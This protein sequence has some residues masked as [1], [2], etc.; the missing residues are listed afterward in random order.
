MSNKLFNVMFIVGVVAV[1]LLF[2]YATYI[3]TGNH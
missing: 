2:T 1:G 3:M